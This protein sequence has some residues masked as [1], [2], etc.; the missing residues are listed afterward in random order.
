[1][2]EVA[3]HY[4]NDS[5]VAVVSIQ[6]AF[7]GFGINSFEALQ[8]IA[9]QY[10][11]TIPIGHSGWQGKPSPLLYTYGARGTPWVV[12]ID[13]AGNIRLNAFYQEPNKSIAFIERLK[14]E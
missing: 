8:K 9:K 4:Q 11:L 5:S 10:S 7:E 1:M 13:R 12:I 6:T 2:Q 3:H 14:A